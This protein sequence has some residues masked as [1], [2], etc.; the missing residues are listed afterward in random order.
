M[1]VVINKKFYKVTS[2]VPA[3]VFCK[4]LSLSCVII[5]FFI[6]RKLLIESMKKYI[7]PPSKEQEKIN[8]SMPIV[9]K[10]IASTEM[11]LMNT[12]TS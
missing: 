5:F 8:T 12:L 6:S 2:P 3:F 7:V 10:E 1:E 4:R 9:L 11:H